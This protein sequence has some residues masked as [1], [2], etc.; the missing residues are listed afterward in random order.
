MT[1]GTT[2]VKQRT[3]VRQ[4]ELVAAALSLAAEQSPGDITT[5]A[6]A[7]AVGISQGAVFRHFDSKEAIWLAAIDHVQSELMERLENA[8]RGLSDPMQALRA[9]FL[10]HAAFAADHP[11][12]PR[13]IFH[14]LQHPGDSP[15]KGKVRRL[16]RE[17][18][19]RLL[20]PL[21]RARDLGRLS[22][23]TDPE[24]AVILFIGALQGLV[25]Q[26]MISGQVK[27]MPRHAPLVFDLLL[28]GLRASAT[29]P[30]LEST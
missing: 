9:M 28:D 24:T 16:M 27:A 25:M 17:Y 10:A 2:T 8:A 1:V 18:R 26:S 13:V 12:A 21:R 29:S 7:N 23:R 6:L 20:T 5:A 30:T 22:P 11:G 14:E 4:A 19:Q 3:D 15:L